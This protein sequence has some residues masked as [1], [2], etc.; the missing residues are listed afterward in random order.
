M[1][2][3]HKKG[4]SLVELMIVLSI[5]ASFTMIA[6]QEGIRKR[7]EMQAKAI[8]Q[9]ILQYNAAVGRY[10]MSSP[11]P[12]DTRVYT[13]GNW[14]RSTEC[15]GGEA[16]YHYL[17]CHYFPTGKTSRGGIGLST[18]M[19]RYPSGEILAR[20]VFDP[21]TNT[22]GRESAV[23]MAIAATI[24]SSP[25]STNNGLIRGGITY[26][27]PSVDIQRPEVA[28]I[29]AGEE[30]RLVSIMTSTEAVGANLPSI[31]DALNQ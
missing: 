14:L 22:Q 15:Y 27:C 26:Y 17:P 2:F 31:M 13:D 29:C 8:G 10:I 28:S 7:D 12:E 20:T 1:P 9:E 3:V 21:I 24:A 19:T 16:D 30:G 6:T 23:M 4:Y 25:S 5:A 11:A 18:T